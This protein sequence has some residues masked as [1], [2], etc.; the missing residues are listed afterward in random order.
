MSAAFSR[1][2]YKLTNLLENGVP[3]LVENR[4]EV[5]ASTQWPYR[6]FDTVRLPT[7]DFDPG[8]AILA[9]RICRWNSVGSNM[10]EQGEPKNKYE[11]NALARPKL[12]I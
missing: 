9:F 8:G 2:T 12:L 1:T 3:L 5:P 7:D 11:L 6:R 4:M 10:S